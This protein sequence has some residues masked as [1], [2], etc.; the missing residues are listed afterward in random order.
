MRSLCD[1][2]ATGEHPVCSDPAST[3]RAEDREHDGE[4]LRQERHREGDA[5][6][7][8]IE[9]P[10]GARSLAEDRVGRNT[11]AFRDANGIAAHEARRVDELVFAVT[12]HARLRARKIA[13]RLEGPLRAPLLEYGEGEYQPHRSEQRHTLPSVA[14]G[15]VER[16][17]ADQQEQHRFAKY[18]REQREQASTASGEDVGALRREP[19][20]GRDA[21]QSERRIFHVRNGRLSH[22]TRDFNS[23]RRS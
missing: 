3:Q 5:R 16:R 13:Q 14:D 17:R 22:R 18:L 9:P 15:E 10:S 6:E 11:V 4:L 19:L 7:Q 12:H 8:R 2:H 21:R 20:G 23:P 1:G